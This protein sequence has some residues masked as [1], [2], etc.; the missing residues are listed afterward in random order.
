MAELFKTGAYYAK[1][2]LIADDGS[3]DTSAAKQDTREAA[4]VYKIA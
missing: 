2:Q 3:A 1:G 4:S